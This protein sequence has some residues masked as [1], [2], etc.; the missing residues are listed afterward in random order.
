DTLLVAVGLKAPWVVK[1]TYDLRM[2]ARGGL[3]RKPYKVVR[4]GH[5]GPLEVRLADKQARHLQGVTGP[6][7]AVPA[8]KDDFEYPVLLP[9]WM[10]MGRTSRSCI[11]V[12]GTVR[13]GDRDHTVS[14]TS[15]A[16]PDQVIAVV[17]AGRLG[18]EVERASLEATPGG[19]AT[20]RAT[21]R[22]APE[23]KGPVVLE[24]VLPSHFAGVRAPAGTL[25]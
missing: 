10:E 18:L 19:S 16:Q 9:P 4:N 3:F 14:Y 7:L 11:M 1:G 15:Q 20:V 5:A 21:V 25:P 22:R 2:A 6:V 12:V 8:G 17:E 23:L 13:V 24:L